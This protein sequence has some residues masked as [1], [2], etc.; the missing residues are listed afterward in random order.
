[1][2]KDILSADHNSQT[3]PVWMEKEEV[4]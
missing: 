2:Y 3:K 4:V 1:L